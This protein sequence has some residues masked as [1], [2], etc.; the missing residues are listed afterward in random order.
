MKSGISEYSETLVYGLAEYYDITLLTDDYKLNNKKLAKSFSQKIY[1]SGECYTGFDAVIYNIGNNHHYHIYM[2]EAMKD[3]PGFIILHDFV[4]YYLSVGIHQSRGDIFQSIYAL[5]GVRGISIVKDSLKQ[6]SN[7][8]LLAHKSIATELPM[9]REII[10]MS[11]G[12]FVHSDYAKNLL[13]NEFIE[14]P[15]HKINL[16]KMNLGKTDIDCYEFAYSR[17][18]IPENAYV[19]G[20]LGFIAETKQNE[21]C[22]KAIKFYNQTHD[23]KI[24]YLMVGEGETLSD[25]LDKYIIKTNFLE[26]EEYIPAV[27]R[28]DL[29]L[30]LRYPTNGETSAALMQSMGL[31]K[32]CIVTDIGWFGEL[33]EGLVK[34]VNWDITPEDLAKVIVELRNS[35][36]AVMMSRAKEYVDIEC[37]PEKIAADIYKFMK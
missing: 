32:P 30:N 27:L 35:D 16:V 24:Y 8:D 36:N 34:K 3:N 17:Y 37:A 14:K 23:D 15:C 9:N 33:P 19:I 22:C 12:V 2:V 7:S 31:G 1:R 20:S 25:Y 13:H 28:C 29:V 18:K 11:K 21:L 6:N 26:K 5:E 4:L 10:E